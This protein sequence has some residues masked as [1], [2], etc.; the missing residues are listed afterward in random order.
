MLI[1]RTLAS[2]EETQGVAGRLAEALGPSAAEAPGVFVAM[3]GGLGAGKTTFVQGFVKALPGGADLYVT[4]P[5]YALAQ[6]YD[7]VPPVTH[8]DL[9]R[10]GSLD[11]LEM[12]GYQDLYF[13]G[14]I[15]LVE[16]A[17]RVPEALPAERVDV[18]LTVSSENVRTLRLTITGSRLE[19][20]LRNIEL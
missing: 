9:Y 13:G 2:A 11:E 16:W 3:L 18:E 12:I 8:M 19:R 17:N 14:G 7:T 1:E 5:T 6:T 4:S 10:L 15:T 20:L